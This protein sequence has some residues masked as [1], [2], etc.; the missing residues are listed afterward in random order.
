MTHAPDEIAYWLEVA[1]ARALLDA[2]QATA[3]VEGDP[4]QARW[5]LD[6]E[7]VTY[8]TSALDIAFFNR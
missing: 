7:R 6:H 3:A 2:Q 8:W 4:L 5:H 1:E